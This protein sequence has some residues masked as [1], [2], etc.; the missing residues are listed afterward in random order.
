MRT[1]VT[2][3]LCNCD[4]RSHPDETLE[5]FVFGQQLLVQFDSLQMAAT[6]ISVGL[7]Q[8]VCP[9]AGELAR[10]HTVELRNSVIIIII[11]SLRRPPP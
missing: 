5:P 8:V 9:L 2:V 4:G 1:A 3:L 11:I 10:S 6:E 7:Q